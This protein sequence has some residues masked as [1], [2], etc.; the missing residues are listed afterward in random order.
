MN[1]TIDDKEFSAIIRKL[2]SSEGSF[3]GIAMHFEHDS[4]VYNDCHK[5]ANDISAFITTLTEKR[6][7]E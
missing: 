1:R 2:A 7:K 5:I 4:V 3:R 6:F